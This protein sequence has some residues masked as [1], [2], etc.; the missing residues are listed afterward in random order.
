MRLRV[1]QVAHGLGLCEVETPAGESA[2]CELAGVSRPRAE[3]EQGINYAQQE[4]RRPV[5]AKLYDIF[6]GVRVW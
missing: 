4:W 6:S 5:A 3:E 2:H 1:N